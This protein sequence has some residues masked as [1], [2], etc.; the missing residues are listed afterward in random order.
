MS[1]ETKLVCPINRAVAAL[2]DK[3]KILIILTLQTGT[4][5][6]GELL[7]HL[8]GIA[9]KVLTR[10]LRS[11]EHDGLVVRTV[12]AEVPPRVEYALTR[13]G[14]SLLPILLQLQSWA[15]ENADE[16]SPEITGHAEHEAAV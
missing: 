13:S 3:W 5:R 15:M 11:L 12:F 1:H 14:L 10:Q 16:L 9:P 8:E 6:F 7:K 2:A 4:V